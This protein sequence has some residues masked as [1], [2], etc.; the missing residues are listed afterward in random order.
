MPRLRKYT[1]GRGYYLAG[2]IPEVGFCTWQIGKEGLAY[3]NARGI[4]S[5]GD[6]LRIDIL[7]EMIDRKLVGTDH[8]GTSPTPAA[9]APQWV[10]ALADGLIKWSQTG[11]VDA[12]A[13]I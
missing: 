5:N 10:K 1:D 12:L 2:H 13:R 4:S 3:L 6:T 11:G 7:R 9:P 8:S